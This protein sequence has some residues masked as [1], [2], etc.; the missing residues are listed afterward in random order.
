M[1]PHDKVNIS[2][3]ANID[4]NST[5]YSLQQELNTTYLT[6]EYDV[7]FDWEL[8]KSFFLSSEFSYTINSQRTD[9]IQYQN[10]NMECQHQQTIP[11]L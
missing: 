1:N 8:P 6:Q 3:G 10:A 9:G 5:K 11:S 2:L 7:S 4:Y